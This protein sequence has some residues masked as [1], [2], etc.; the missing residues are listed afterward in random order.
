MTKECILDKKKKQ[1]FKPRPRYFSPL[2]RALW[3]VIGVAAYIQ[4]LLVQKKKKTRCLF[5]RKPGTIFRKLDSGQS[6][7]LTNF[8]EI[9]RLNTL[10][11][12]DICLKNL[13]FALG[14]Q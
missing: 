13:K 14:R 6:E 8:L 1:L 9:A 7:I 5:S 12:Q 11:T 2:Q 10:R 4:V 3:L